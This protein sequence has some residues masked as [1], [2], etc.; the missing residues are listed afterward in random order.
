MIFSDHTLRV[1]LY[2]NATDMRKSFKGLIAL[3]KNQL[4][5]DPLSGHLFVFINRRKTYMKVLYYSQGGF[6]IW[7]K[8]LTQGQFAFQE[9]REPNKKPMS[10]QD[11]QCLVEGIEYEKIKFRKRYQYTRNPSTI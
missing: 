2:L 5:E 4:D 3:V 11:L 9:S 7:M 8:K 10:W 1:W 6:C